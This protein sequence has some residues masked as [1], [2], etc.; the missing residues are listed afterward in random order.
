MLVHNDCAELVNDPLEDI[1]Y[2]DKV[3]KQMYMGDN[4][5]FPLE[6]DN[7]GALGKITKIIDADGQTYTKLT[8]DG[9][10]KDSEGVLEY[11]YNAAKECNHRF[12]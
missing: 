4:H 5:S 1:K 7:F 12:F 10:Y 2:S 8:T 6:V 3:M 9:A 11:I